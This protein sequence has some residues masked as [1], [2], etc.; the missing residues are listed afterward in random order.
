M[1]TE[2]ERALDPKHIFVD[3]RLKGRCVYCGGAPETADH[4]PSRVLLDEPLP[5]NLPVV[6]ACREC[7]RSFSLDE[8]YFACLLECIVTGTTRNEALGREKIKRALARNS[9][10]VSALESCRWEDEKGHIWWNPDETR[11]RNVILKLA[12]GHAA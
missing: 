10:L 9:R 12:R 5:K 8:E 6:E 3:E 7:N 1:Q 4:V 2:E 11:I